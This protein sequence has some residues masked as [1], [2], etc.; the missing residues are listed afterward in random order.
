MWKKSWYKLPG[1]QS[2]SEEPFPPAADWWV[3]GALIRSGGLSHF[4]VLSPEE[5]PVNLFISLHFWE[6]RKQ[7]WHFILD[8][9]L[10]IQRWLWEASLDHVDQHQGDPVQVSSLQFHLQT[11]FCRSKADNTKHSLWWCEWMSLPDGVTL[12]ISR[13]KSQRFKHEGSSQTGSL[14][15]KDYAKYGL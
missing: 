9:K 13:Q 6:N 3:W 10:N 12:I 14:K 8:L 7:R 4:W 5:S 2:Q 11:I 15:K 1:A